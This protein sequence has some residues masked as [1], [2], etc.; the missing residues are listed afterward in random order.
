MMEHLA[1]LTDDT[2]VRAGLIDIDWS[3][4]FM[5][6]LFIAFVVLL[7]RIITRPLVDNQSA[8]YRQMDG[9]RADA[10]AADLSAAETRIEYESRLTLA[11]QTA[12]EVRD[13][14][15]D[16]A[17]V[18]SRE[19]VEQVRIDTEARTQA[20]LTELS[21]AAARARLELKAQTDALATQLAQKL[22]AGGK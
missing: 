7:T 10:A 21:A 18:S 12:V 19:L 2:I 11:R 5:L 6:G 15:R 14:L 8:R 17:A 4:V 13:E 22:I 9:A 1:V 20:G 3:F 16:A